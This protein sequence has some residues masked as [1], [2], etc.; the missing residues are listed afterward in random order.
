M[1]HSLLI[2]EPLSRAVAKPPLSLDRYASEDHH[3]RGVNLVVT[4]RRARTAWAAWVD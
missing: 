1:I 4:E 3:D 2:N